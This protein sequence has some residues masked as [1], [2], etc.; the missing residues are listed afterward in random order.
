MD[1]KTF[2]K[3]FAAATLPAALHAETGKCETPQ[4]TADAGAVR[5][6]LSTF[7][8]REESTLD[9]PTTFKLLEERGR[10]CCRALDFRQKLIRDSA[11]SVDKLVELMGKIVGPENC[12]REGDTVTLIYPSGKCG[13]GWSPKRPPTPGDP[14]CECSRANNQLIFETVAGRPVR[15]EVTES[16]RRGGKVCRFLI[17]LV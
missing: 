5:Q 16:P 3:T 15:A 13:C 11:G 17:H 8:A 4:C 2:L 10:A 1:R 6:F 14:Y 9:R 12:R 7:V